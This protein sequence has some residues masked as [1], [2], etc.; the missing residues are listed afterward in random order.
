MARARRARPNMNVTPLVDVVLVLLII[1]MVVVPAM[2]QD[3]KVE[4][5]SVVHA[6]EDPKS[7]TDPFVLAI[8]ADGTLYFDK[9]ALAPEAFTDVLRRANRAEPNRRLT[10][11]AD[12]EV[13]YSEVRRLYQTVQSLGFPGISLRVNQRAAGK[14]G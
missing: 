5:A 6:D 2:S 10:L 13:K 11:K 8:S 7:K 4:L 9:Q 14:E 3:A 12:K 1:F